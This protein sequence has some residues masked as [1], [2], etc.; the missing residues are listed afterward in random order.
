[1]QTGTTDIPLTEKGEELIRGLSTRV[2]GEGSTL[3]G[4]LLPIFLL[5]R[6]QKFWTLQNC[7]MCS[8]A[9][10]AVHRKHTTFSSQMYRPT[11]NQ[12]AK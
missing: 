12:K 2:V 5:I 7:L 6:H 9:L 8:S 3:A 1:M 10:G 11:S 4:F